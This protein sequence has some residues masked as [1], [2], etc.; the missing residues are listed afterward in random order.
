MK[1]LTVA[2]LLAL[3][4]VAVQAEPYQSLMSIFMK[5]TNEE[6]QS[7]DVP[8]IS[9]DNMAFETLKSDALSTTTLEPESTT[10]E[11]TTVATTT[12][13]RANKDKRKKKK[14]FGRKYR[15]SIL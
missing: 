12:T 9:F 8:F 14:R 5:S 11:S 15:S 1:T 7:M 6:S 2:V 3:S 10:L 4:L 13:K